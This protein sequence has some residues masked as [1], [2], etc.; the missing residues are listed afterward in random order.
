M[1]LRKSEVITVGLAMS[2]WGEFAFITATTARREGLMDAHTFSAVILAVM[3]SVV[4]SPTLLRRHLSRSSKT[5][6]RAP[7]P[8]PAHAPHAPRTQPRTPF[9][10]PSHTLRNA[11]RTPHPAHPAHPAH[12]AHPAP[13]TPHMS[14]AI[15]RIEHAIEQQQM[16]AR[17]SSGVLDVRVCY[18]LQ[19]VFAPTWG[20][21]ARLFSSVRSLQMEVLDFRSHHLQ[22]R[23]L[24]VNEIFLEDGQ[25][26][27]P[28][29]LR[30]SAEKQQALSSP[31]PRGGC[32]LTCCRLRPRVL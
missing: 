25:L 2:A 3:M 16:G 5:V 10:R 4:L 6:R 18:R 19:T 11:L 14:Q 31:E 17:P 26:R 13:R 30:L 12:A 29:T 32:D 20:L 23:N 7:L 8:S 22:D 9:A 15:A 24:V 27:A 28:P 1:P 21:N